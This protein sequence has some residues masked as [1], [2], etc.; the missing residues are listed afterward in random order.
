[1]VV[2]IGC[3]CRWCVDLLLCEFVGPN[4]YRNAL[5]KG[6]KKMKRLAGQPFF[7][8]FK[9]DKR[10]QETLLDQP[11]YTPSNNH[12]QTQPTIKMSAKGAGKGGKGGKGGRGASGKKSVSRSAKVSLTLLSHIDECLYVILHC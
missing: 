10:G 3:C 6:L 7:S 4:L 11:K 12:T 5:Q 9:S 2:G 8:F 1:L